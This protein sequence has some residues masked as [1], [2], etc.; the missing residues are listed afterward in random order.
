MTAFLFPEISYIDLLLKE[1][2]YELISKE[3]QIYQCEYQNKEFY[4][5]LTGYGKVNITVSLTYLIMKYEIS[6]IISCGVAGA[7]PGYSLNFLDIII[8]ECVTQA[9][10]DF[11]K[12]NI[13]NKNIFLTN[14]DLNKKIIDTI[15]FTNNNYHKKSVATSEKFYPSLDNKLLKL[16]IF[17]YDY[18][19]GVLGQVLEKKKIPFSGIKI[20][21]YFLNDWA[22][23]QF[24]YYKDPAVLK[25]QKVILN[26]LR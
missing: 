9:D 21:T 3:Y 18:D 10:I 20:I 26:Y 2:D 13:E 4:I 1:V 17:I 15:K 24:N 22:I 16:N 23:N 7:K 25:L 14:D 19:L 11:S 5:L 12:M 6:E 8:A